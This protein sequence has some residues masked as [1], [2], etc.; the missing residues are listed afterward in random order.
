M[1]PDISLKSLFFCFLEVLAKFGQKQTNIEKTKKN[2]KPKKTKK[3]KNQRLGDYMRPDISLRSFFLCF[4]FS[5][6]V[7]LFFWFSRGFF[8]FLTKSSKSLEKRK[9]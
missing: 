5:F 9:H 3:Q 1:R 8:W 7:F 2:K 6:F 4:F